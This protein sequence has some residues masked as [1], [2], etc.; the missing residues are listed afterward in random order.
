[1]EQYLR[2][3]PSYQQDDCVPWLAL[4]EFASNNATSEATKCSPF[5]AVMGMDP[6][7]TFEGIENEPRDLRMVDADQV[8]KVMEQIHEHLRLEMRRSQDIMEKGANRNRIPAPRILEGTKVWLDARHI[9]TVRP[10]QKLDWKRLGPYVVKRM[11]SPYAYELELPV[12]LKIHPVHHVSLLEPV[13][14]DPLPSAG[15][16]SASPGGSGGR[17]TIPG[18]TGGGFPYVS[19]SITVFAP[20]DGV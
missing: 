1:M 13:A 12:G 11:V 14:G 2:V 10:S 17:P 9:R 5:L 18:G 19:K 4:A 15:G 20:V 16:Y 8:Q 7:M 6:R 3:F